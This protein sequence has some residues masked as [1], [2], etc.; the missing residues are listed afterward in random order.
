MKVF[1]VEYFCGVF[2][3]GLLCCGIGLWGVVFWC[4]FD[5]FVVVG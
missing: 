3:F 4:I 5:F 1:D 2:C